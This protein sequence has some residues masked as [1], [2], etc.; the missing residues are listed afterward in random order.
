[1]KG[2]KSVKGYNEQPIR[3]SVVIPAYNS[4]KYLA[5]TIDSVLAQT[6][7]ADEIIVVDDGST[8]DTESV[9]KSYVNKIRY[10]HQENAGPSAARNTGIRAAKYDWIAFLDS[11]DQWLP[12]KLELQIEL[13]SRHRSLVWAG[14]NYIRCLNDKNKQ[15]PNVPLAKAEKLLAGKEYYDDFYDAFIAGACG[16]TGT[17]IIKKDSLCQAGLFRVGL[18]K[19]EDIDMWLRIAYQWPRFGYTS[20]PLAVYHMDIPTSISQKHAKAAMGFDFVDRHIALAEEHGVLDRFAKC[21]G[22]L[23]RRRIRTLFFGGR[24]QQVKKI[25]LKYKA[26]LPAYYRVFMWLLGSFPRL[27]TNCVH[28]ISKIIRILHLRRR[29]LRPPI[30]PD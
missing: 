20:K 2:K 28:I 3:V 29:V 26:Y 23:V 30:K 19:A 25:I 12:E 14:A 9:A 17:M 13:L 5:R 1:M 18:L 22:T 4:G 11:D 15:S 21:A 7:S 8:D 6:R 16:W 27:T 24:G 10:I